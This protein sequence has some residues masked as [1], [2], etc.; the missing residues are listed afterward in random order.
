MSIVYKA[1][2]ECLS[3]DGTELELRT[4]TYGTEDGVVDVIAFNMGAGNM[5]FVSHAEARELASWLIG[6]ALDSVDEPSF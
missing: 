2:A 1:N 6:H 3:G 4:D 5:V